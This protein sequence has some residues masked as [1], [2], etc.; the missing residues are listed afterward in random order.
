M[1]YKSKKNTSDK[2][3]IAI[4][5][6]GFEAG[7]VDSYLSYLLDTWPSQDTFYIFH[8]RENRGI[9]R[10]KKIMT[11]KSVKFISVKTVFQYYDS[12]SKRS[13][14]LKYLR[15]IMSPLLYLINI[16]LYKK[17][18]EGFEFDVL[19]AQNG[20][21]PGSY[22]VLS[23]CIAAYLAKINVVCLVIHHA[24][25]RPILGHR[26]FRSIIEKNLSKKLSSIVAISQA[27][28]KTIL[29]NTKLFNNSSKDVTVIEN[30]VIMP[31]KKKY[32]SHNQK[33]QKIGIIGRLDPHKGHDDFLKALSLL[34]NKHLERIAVEFIGSYED[35]DFQR[36][37]NYIK[38]FG[39][40]HVVE[41]KGYIDLP[42][43]EVI[44][45]LDLVAMV[46]KDFEGFG[47][48]IVEALHLGVPVLA[49]R[50]GIVPDLFSN[51]SVMTIEP[52]DY[53]AM[54]KAIIKFIETKDKSKL[55]TKKVRSQ[56]K[57]YDAKYASRRYREHLI[58]NYYS[59]KN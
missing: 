40:S 12:K 52:N 34:S 9:D 22:A 1:Y 31:M 27:T 11:N 15:H 35:C 43:S 17:E 37:S 26:L 10:L 58:N 53:Q 42:I 39:L 38:K 33:I 4:V 46:T 14:A 55:I 21:Y 28:K 57:K 29:D 13:L 5:W 51:E 45:S 2:L 16:F 3:Q 30:G 41:I 20:G 54:S 48:T 49:T 32:F 8:N 47:L 59:S 18:F 50:V 25:H 23:A 19:V 7:G 44:L 24:A 36:V 6:E 56:L